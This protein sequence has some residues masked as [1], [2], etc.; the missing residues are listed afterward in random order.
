MFKISKYSDQDIHQLF[1]LL[2][3]KQRQGSSVEYEIRIDNFQVIPRTADLNRFYFYRDHLQE[4]SMT[5]T[6]MVYKGNSRR[7]DKFIFKL[8]ALPDAEKEIQEKI[9][10]ALEKQRKEVE[11]QILQK[12]VKK[13]KKKNR[14]LEEQLETL[15][16][17]GKNGNMMSQLMGVWNRFNGNVPQEAMLD[18]VSNDQLLMMLSNMKN[19]LGVEQFQS[20]LGTAMLMAEHPHLLPKVRSFVEQHTQKR[21]T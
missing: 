12:K 13:L 3:S 11:Y 15:E 21:S 9:N 18:G 19:Q 14:N 1:D 17:E 6:F 10:E 16:S 5:L 2:S 20:L 8:N 4:D 7:Y